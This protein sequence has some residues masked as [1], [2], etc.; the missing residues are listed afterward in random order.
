[1]AADRV[2][3]DKWLWAARFFK[4]RSRAAQAVQ[5]GKV[6]V[7][8]T[9]VKPARLVTVGDQLKVTKGVFTFSIEVAAISKFRRPAVEAQLLYSETPESIREREKTRE[10]RSMVRASQLPPAGKPDKRERRKIRDF[11]RKQ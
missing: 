2:R 8:G 7:N 3:L 4:T 9:R 11:I 1:M 10:M 6:H 5:G